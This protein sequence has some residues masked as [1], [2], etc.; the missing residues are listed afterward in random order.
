MFH[1][2]YQLAL[3]AKLLVFASDSNGYS[4]RDKLKMSTTIIRWLELE[5]V[6]DDSLL[7]L[8]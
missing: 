7:E 3:D 6:R 4:R 5:Q 8:L 1:I 2:Q